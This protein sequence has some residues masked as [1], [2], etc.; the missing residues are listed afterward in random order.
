[1]SSEERLNG[2]KK[3][4]AQVTGLEDPRL[5]LVSGDASFRKYYR[6]E[7][8]I[9]VDAPPATEKNAEFVEYSGIYRRAGI[10]V[11]EVLQADLE[12]GYLCI[13][14]LGST[15]FS[16]YHTPQNEES[17]Y[18][19]ACDLAVRISQIEHSFPIYDRPFIERELQIFSDWY[20]GAHAGIEL[21]PAEQNVWSSVCEM[22]VQND[23]QQPTGTMH[24]DFHCRNIMITDNEQLAV[25]DF[26]D[27]VTGPVTY[28]LVSLLKDCYVTLEPSL[29]E[30]LTARAY[31]KLRAAGTVDCS[32]EQF[33]EFMDLTGMQRHLKA[34]GIFCRLLYRDGRDGY[35]QYLPRTFGYVAETAAKYPQ[36]RDF[37]SLLADRFTKR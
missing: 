37:A 32:L 3:F 24:R 36:F 25:I 20:V 15:M 5:Q 27:T 35:L 9:F 26:Q 8:R 19:M 31:E 10:N 13:T 16:Q 2:L 7:G 14:D 17:L 6:A 18:S 1:M 30:R 12:Q 29:R 34:I 23:L 21:T 28:D 11:P 22:L 4:A 33:T